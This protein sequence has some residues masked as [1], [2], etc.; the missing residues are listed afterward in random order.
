MEKNVYKHGDGKLHKN[1]N[2]KVWTVLSSLV[3]LKSTVEIIQ[4]QLLHSAQ[5]DYINKGYSGEI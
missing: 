3:V 1:K 5:D 4:R 2:I